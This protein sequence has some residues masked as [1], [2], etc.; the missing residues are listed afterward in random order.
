MSHF[1]V[2]GRSD[3]PLR[4]KHLRR[5]TLVSITRSIKLPAAFHTTS[6]VFQIQ[7]TASPVSQPPTTTLR[8]HENAPPYPFPPPPP[9]LPHYRMDSPLLPLL[10]PPLLRPLPRPRR[11]HPPARP[12]AQR[13]HRGGMDFRPGEVAVHIHP[14]KGGTDYGGGDGEVWG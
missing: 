13:L 9:P 3:H 10:G 8:H 2:L 14:A 4:S 11:F 7:T 5:L 6:P 12:L 1:I